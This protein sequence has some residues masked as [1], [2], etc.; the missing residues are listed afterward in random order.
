M[1]N[2]PPTRELSNAR[3]K[4]LDLLTC[5]GPTNGVG[6]FSPVSRI[7]LMSLHDQCPGLSNLR[8]ACVGR[9]LGTL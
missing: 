7:Y 6:V 4:N 5:L 2:V 9:G 1:P 8:R 3:R